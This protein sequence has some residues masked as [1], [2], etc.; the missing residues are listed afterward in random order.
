MAHARGLTGGTPKV[1]SLASPSR[2][3][4]PRL[5]LSFAIAGAVSFWLPDVAV[6]IGAGPNFD[7]RHVWEI[8][9]LMPAAFLLTYLVARKSAIKR[10]FRW[11]GA[12][13]LLGVWITGGLFMT[14]AAM[15]SGSG[16][17]GAS[18]VWRLVIIVL[19]VIPIVT[20]ILATYDGSLFA[21]LLLTLG[22]LLLS[23]FRASRILSTSGPSSATISSEE[24]PSQQR[25]KVA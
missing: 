2:I 7:S 3:K 25:S 8:T 6:H 9:I 19:S 1:E 23:G 20:Y 18:G 14:I 10:D 21:L 15:A 22:A 24:S 4:L 5:A 16:F 13:M 17:V 11:V 12:A